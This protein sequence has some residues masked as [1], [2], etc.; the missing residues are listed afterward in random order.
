ML[1]NNYSREIK[2]QASSRY[3]G[4]SINLRDERLKDVACSLQQAQRASMH[5]ALHWLVVDEKKSARSEMLDL[6]SH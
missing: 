6:A 5:F 1:R 4:S 3:F 2:L